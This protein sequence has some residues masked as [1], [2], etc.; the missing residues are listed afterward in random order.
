[1]S[2]KLSLVTLVLV[3]VAGAVAAADV[4]GEVVLV[5]ATLGV[6]LAVWAYGRSFV[7]WVAAGTHYGA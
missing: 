4:P 1:M 2:K 5:A 3:A 7:A 6:A